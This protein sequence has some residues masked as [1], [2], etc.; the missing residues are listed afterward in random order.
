MP[1]K[2][3][4]IFPLRFAPVR[5]CFTSFHFAKTRPAFA[6]L[7]FKKANTFPSAL[8]STWSGGIE[9]HFCR[10]A[11]MY[12]QSFR[13]AFVGEMVVTNTTFDLEKFFINV[14]PLKNFL[15]SLLKFPPV[16]I[17]QI[18]KG[19]LDYRI[20]TLIVILNHFNRQINIF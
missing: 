3:P 18:E 7:R 20:D 11:K 10:G 9:N 8:G 17:V 15:N 1:G 13:L 5:P 19:S 14:F 12:K 6:P 2:S 16:R 4:P